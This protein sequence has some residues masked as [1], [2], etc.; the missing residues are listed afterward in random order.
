MSSSDRDGRVQGGASYEVILAG[1][2]LLNSDDFPT[3]SR[4]LISPDRATISCRSRPSAF[5]FFSPYIT[6]RWTP[7]MPNNEYETSSGN[8]V[9]RFDTNWSFSRA[10]PIPG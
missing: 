3:Q 8:V 7:K 5:C 9:T 2:Q 6:G 4:A 10:P 1:K